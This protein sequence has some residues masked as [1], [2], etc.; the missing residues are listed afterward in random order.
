MKNIVY[1]CNYM[2]ED[3]LNER[4]NN[5]IFSQAGNNKIKSIYKS[6]KLNKCKIRI[7]SQGLMNNKT[8]KKYRGF[9]S[10][11]N[12][13]IKYIPIIDI[14][15]INI[16][17][18]IFWGFKEVKK[19]NKIA[20]IDAII[21]YNYRL[22]TCVVAYLAKKKLNIPIILEYEDGYYDLKDIS[23]IKR[24]I[25]R[26][27]E[28]K[29]KNLIDGAI[30]VTS[31]LKDRVNDKYVVVRG[32]SNEK[33]MSKVITKKRN[34]IPIVMYSGGLEEVRGIKVLLESLKY[35]SS[36]F[37]LI[38]TGRGECEKNILKNQDKRIEF[39]GYI[40]YEDVI[41]NMINAD[42]LINCQL[43]NSQFSSCSFPSKIFEYLSTENIVISSNISDIKE[44]MED[45]V[46]IYKD[47]NPVMLA[48]KIDDALL[49]LKDEE[50]LGI[51]KSK[52]NKFNKDN[53]SKN[54]GKKINEVLLEW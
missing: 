33:I 32:V 45:I 47:D 15:V 22:E 31:C 24:L 44:A 18:S 53:S 6:L 13:D 28:N 5:N 29:I 30:L 46:S 40:S 16:L 54:I 37:K 27:L 34:T 11:I 19:A 52:I 9:I 1:I 35:T 2:L 25:S 48:Q 51:I 12:S 21:F 36:D 23:Y 43:E 49:L 26:F 39:L 38:I 4:H 17:S 20:K 8:F 50:R 7:L 3:V 10:K 42:I 14:P 41:E